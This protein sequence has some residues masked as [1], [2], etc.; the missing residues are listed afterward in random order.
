VALSTQKLAN[1]CGVEN[2]YERDAVLIPQVIKTRLPTE[3]TE[4]KDIESTV[5]ADGLIGWWQKYHAA[6]VERKSRLAQRLSKSIDP[7]NAPSEIAGPTREET[8]QKQLESALDKEG[9]G[10]L[11]STEVRSRRNFRSRSKSRR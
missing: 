9:L 4:T 8:L 10:L 6:T 2:L 3:M 1:T 5:R 7:E 11:Q